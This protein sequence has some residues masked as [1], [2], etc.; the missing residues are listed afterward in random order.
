MQFTLELDSI[1]GN[2][3]DVSGNIRDFGLDTCKV[4]PV[5]RVQE[6]FKQEVTRS[7]E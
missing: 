6:K 3:R 4:S 5:E 2:T 1:A 7:G